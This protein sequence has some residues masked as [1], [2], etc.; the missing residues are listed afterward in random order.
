MLNRIALFILAVLMPLAAPATAL[1]QS[2]EGTWDFRVEEVTIFRFDIEAGTDGEWLGQWHRPENFNTDGN[3]FANLGGGV[4]TTD[5]M[6]GIEFLGLVE[7][8]FDDPR[9]GAVPDIFR[10]EVTGDDA[11]KML[12]VGTDLAPYRLVR[13]GQDDPIGDWDSERIYRR[14]LPQSEAESE[15]EVLEGAARGAP[16]IN[17]IDVSPVEELAG[18]AAE[19]DGSGEAAE[20]LPASDDA[21]DGGSDGADENEEDDGSLLGE[22]FLEGL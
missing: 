1:A 20:A 15:F 16:A 14:N 3:N 13:A 22:D 10:F 17:F 11:A 7:L 4:K 8:S 5:S 18:G 12:Y 9:P 21:G 19:T 2:I 6:T